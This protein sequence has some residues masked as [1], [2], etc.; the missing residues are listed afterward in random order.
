MEPKEMSPEQFA[1]RLDAL[2]AK[3]EP[4]LF[5]HW[6]DRY[7]DGRRHECFYSK[8]C[9]EV[10]FSAVNIDAVTQYALA[11]IVARL[12]GKRSAQWEM[13]QALGLNPEN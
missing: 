11:K 1:D 13:R 5:T 2:K 9:G 4:L 10:D 7:P 6:E 12:D 3:L 8:Y